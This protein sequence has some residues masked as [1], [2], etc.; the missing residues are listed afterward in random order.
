MN[1]VY[2]S[3]DIKAMDKMAVEGGQSEYGLVKKAAACITAELRKI[4]SKTI[5]FFC[6][7]G[8][9]G[10]D[11]IASAIDLAEEYDIT[12]IIIGYTKKLGETPR[13]YLEE[14][15]NKNINLIF[16]DS[17]EKIDTVKQLRE[18][19]IAVDAILGTGASRPLS[20]LIEQ[21]V[22]IINGYKNSVKVAIDI[23]TGVSPD[24]GQIQSVCVKADITL[25]MQGYKPGLL[26]FPGAVM[27]GKVLPK[28]AFETDYVPSKDRFYF[29]ANCV[30]SLKRNRTTNKG[31]YGRLAIV[32]GS[33]G[34][35]G[36]AYLCTMAAVR[37][38]AGTVTVAAPKSAA[39]VIRNNV[40]EAMMF[41]LGE[42]DG[43]IKYD[44]AIRT[45]FDNKNAAIIGP[46]LGKSI[47]VVKTIQAAIESG[48]K[49]VID[50]DALNS[51][52]Q[53]DVNIF[54]QA[55]G[56]L[57][58]TPHPAELARLL[59]CTV[60]DIIKDPIISAERIAEEY[61]IVCALK[62]AHTIVASHDKT[63]IINTGTAGM[64]K[65]GSGDVLSGAI[66]A[67]IA[68]GKDLF[69]GACFAAYVCGLAGE[70]AAQELGTTFM[71][72]SDTIRHLGEIYKM[73]EN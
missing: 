2:L 4:P 70:K 24:T 33:R 18:P 8:N 29:D 31:D 43:F 20:G 69:Y 12:V 58:I 21:A 6:G 53:T 16:A 44:H 15:K 36:A 34:M 35:T 19:D 64:A 32:A 10:A 73:F 49:L 56:R 60:D 46:G 65:G 62:M 14:T 51:I 57:V 25:A 3:S 28:K 50:A 37:S 40:F 52:A 55:S 1:T 41:E 42:Q 26:M 67:L 22:N 5:Y 54:K 59:K 17:T 9:N 72:P 63:A 38:G 27:S 71:L 61:G 11:G 66:G 48:V 68:S 39:D 23:P 13:Q 30:Q 47:D 7:L 45:L